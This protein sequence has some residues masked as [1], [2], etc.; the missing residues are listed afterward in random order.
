MY[1]FLFQA[2][3]YTLYKVR[4]LQNSISADAS[5]R[6]AGP[7]VNKGHCLVSQTKGKQKVLFVFHPPV[8]SVQPFA[9]SGGSLKATVTL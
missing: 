4:E 1:T 8:P 3:S 5:S 7:V 6:T 2:F 9:E